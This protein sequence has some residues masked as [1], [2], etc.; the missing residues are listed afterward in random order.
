MFGEKEVRK[1]ISDCN[2]STRE[3]LKVIKWMRKCIGKNH[4]APHLIETIKEHMNH[5]EDLHESDTTVF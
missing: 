2:G 5:L 1:L 4:F 3:I